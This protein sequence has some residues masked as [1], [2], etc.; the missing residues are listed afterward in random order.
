MNSL[1]PLVET[2]DASHAT[3]EMCLTIFLL[4]CNKQLYALM[5]GTDHPKNLEALCL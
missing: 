3:L 1:L 4:G 5:R 2:L